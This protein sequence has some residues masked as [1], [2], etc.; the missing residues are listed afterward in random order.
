MIV[1]FSLHRLYCSD[2]TKALLT[3]YVVQGMVV[4][5]QAP[6]IDVYLLYIII[7]YCMMTISVGLL[8]VCVCV[9]EFGDYDPS[10]HGTDYLDDFP[11]LENSVRH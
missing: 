6:S 8:C 11:L 1:L 4:L 3:S 10:E 5:I 2:D 9:G 7:H